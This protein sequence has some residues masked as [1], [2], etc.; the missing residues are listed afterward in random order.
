L[1]ETLERLTLR[2]DPLNSNHKAE[3]ITLV[4][5]DPNSGEINTDWPKNDSPLRI[6]KF[7]KQI[8]KSYKDRYKGLPPHSE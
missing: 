6:E 5:G 8:E 7:S 2:S 1:T 3:T 4:S